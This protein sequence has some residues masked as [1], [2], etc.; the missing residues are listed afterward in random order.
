MKLTVSFFLSFLVSGGC[1]F[2][3]I[4][5]TCIAPVRLCTLSKDLLCEY[6]CFRTWLRVWH[7]KTWR[8]DFC[9]GKIKGKHVIVNSYISVLLEA[10]GFWVLLKALR[11]IVCFACRRK[12]ALKRRNHQ[13]DY[14][15]SNSLY[16]LT[17]SACPK[18]LSGSLAYTHHGQIALKQMCQ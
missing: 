11:K 4:L 6:V 16:S 5:M 12:H 17:S 15:E 9:Y 18:S 1:G 7:C 14:S 8:I 13:L 3:H 2:G 10:V